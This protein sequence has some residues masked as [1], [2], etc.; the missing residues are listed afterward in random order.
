MAIPRNQEIAEKLG[1]MAELLEQQGGNPFRVRAYRQAAATLERLDQDIGEL[2]EREGPRG[3]T[4]LPGIGKGIASAIVELV[5]RG[6]WSQLERLRGSLDPEQLFRSVPGIGPELAKR[7]HDTL[8]LDS[9]QTLENAAWDGRLEQ[10]PGIGRRRLQAIRAA[11]ASLLRRPRSHRFRFA[12][13]GPP[14]ELLLEV[15]RIY[16][17]RAEADKLPKIA[18]RRFNPTGEAWLP[19]LHL[20]KG[21]WHFTAMYS[22]SPLAHQLHRTHDWVVIYYYDDHQQE[23]QS[24][25]VTETRGPRAGQRVIRGFS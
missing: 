6:R 8:H 3:L 20:E 11:L 15:D 24:T 9:L 7:I 18:P 21:G 17:E 5:T 13:E 1:E 10:V 22:N 25:V 4:A 12:G 19:V 14:A 23:G 16:R 2:V